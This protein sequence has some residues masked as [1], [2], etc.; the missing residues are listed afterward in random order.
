MKI[1][2]KS[3]TGKRRDLDEDSITILQSDTVHESETMQAA[4]LVVADGIGGHN[5]GEIASRL[6]SRG[7][8]QKMVG[9]MFERSGSVT[10]MLEKTIKEV[11]REL[12]EYTEMNPQHKGMGTTITAAL[13]QG[14]QVSIGHVGDTRAYI[15]N[16]S[17][18]QI[19]TDHSLVQELVDNGELTKEEARVHPQKHI[20][21]RAVGIYEDV[22]VDTATEYIY[23]DDYLLLCCDG[24]TDM[25]PDE[26]IYTII[27]EH[28]DPQTIC[29]ILVE[30][31]N[32]YGGFDNISVIVAQFDEL[33][34][35][36]DVLSDETHVKKSNQEVNECSARNVEHR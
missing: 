20:I 15:I 7:T 18:S 34:K 6:A 1:G 17:I 29:D 10:D 36:K 28:D 11:N 33:K 3:S 21:T 32:A 14:N 16:T 2:F 12:F 30:T 9:A 31:A 24:L 19:T 5:A 25:V 27:T 8:A 35:K 22:E 23:G 4:L 26:E 13:I